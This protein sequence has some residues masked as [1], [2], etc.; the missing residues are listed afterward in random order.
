MIWRGNLERGLCGV[1]KAT[2]TAFVFWFGS[3]EKNLKTDSQYSC[4]DSNCASLYVRV[5]NVRFMSLHDAVPRYLKVRNLKF[6][7]LCSWRCKCCGKWRCVIG[8]YLPTFRGSL[9]PPSLGCIVV[10][11]S[12]IYVLEGHKWPVKKAYVHRDRKGSNPFTVLRTGR[13][14]DTCRLRFGTL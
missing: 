10:S 3:L 9:L 7:W 8:E 13:C 1:F 2:V 14:L 6:L 5:L 11:E 4:R 12:V